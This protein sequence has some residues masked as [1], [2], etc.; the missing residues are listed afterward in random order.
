MHTLK[1]FLPFKRLAGLLLMLFIS[2][3][4]TAQYLYLGGSFDYS[5]LKLRTMDY[6]R[7]GISRIEFAPQ[8]IYRPI[9][10]LG[11]GASFGLPLSTKVKASLKGSP[12]TDGYGFSDWGGYSEYSYR[13]IPNAFDYELTA[14]S[15]ASGFLRIYLEDK[16]NFYVDLRVTMARFEEK[17]VLSRNAQSG[18]YDSFWEVY[19]SPVA[20]LSTNETWQRTLIAPGLS[21]GM[22][23][24]VGEHFFISFFL[25][26]DYYSFTEKSF[27][28]TVSY[29]EDYDGQMEYA[30]FTSLLTGSR[31]VFRAGLGLG[32]YF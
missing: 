24:H 13:H 15:N 23:P 1:D 20:K 29:T 8:I 12:T 2:A 26:F 3:S 19:R 30:T 14:G 7:N 10:N 5:S 6:K 9:R 18:Y 27:S 22:A 32:T 4:A 16:L 31:L 17:L 25:G 21:L 11:I 28:M